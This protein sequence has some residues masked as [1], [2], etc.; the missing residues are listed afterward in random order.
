MV[1]SLAQRRKEIRGVHPGIVG[2]AGFAPLGHRAMR[3]FK[4]AIDKR[5]V[6]RDDNVGS[7]TRYISLWINQLQLM[8]ERVLQWI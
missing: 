1:N 6:G 8:P 3:Q 2:L 7:S 4:E 5:A